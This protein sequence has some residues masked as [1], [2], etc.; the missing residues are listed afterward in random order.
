MFKT[1]LRPLSSLQYQCQRQFATKLQA[2]SKNNNKDSA[3]R[4]L[5]L[6]KFG[7]EEVFPNEIIARQ[8][9]LRWHAGEN[10][11][12]GKDHT[13]HSRIEVNSL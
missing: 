4:R 5:G 7:G 9:G 1:L 6:K 12:I 8:R 3:G 13:I 10:T 2:T 11:R